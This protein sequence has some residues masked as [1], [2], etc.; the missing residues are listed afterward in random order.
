MPKDSIVFVVAHPDDV[1]FSFGGTAWLLKDN[2]TLHVLCASKGERGYDSDWHGEGLKPPNQDVAATREKE[3]RDACDLLG[4]DLAFLGEM[5]GEIQP[6]RKTCDHVSRMLSLIKPLTVITHG[7]FEKKD[8]SATFSIA[9]LAL[10]QSGRF[11]T[12]E[13]YTGEAYDLTRL[14]LFVNITNAIE[15]KRKLISCHRSHMNDN[16]EE[17]IEAI[18]ERNRILGKMS[19][20]DYAEAFVTPLPMVNTRW[21]RKAETGHTL[22]DLP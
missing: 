10:Q 7:P 5:D 2:Y 16:P 22:L 9:Y 8:H 13:V 3:E 12:T 6:S 20:C 14:S 19:L 18:L 17:G 15:G 4:A 11:W 21:G 1:A